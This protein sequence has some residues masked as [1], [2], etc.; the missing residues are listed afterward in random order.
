M[1]NEVFKRDISFINV[2][3]DNYFNPEKW[4]P[5]RIITERIAENTINNFKLADIYDF[6]GEFVRN[7]DIEHPKLEKKEVIISN[8]YNF[9]TTEYNTD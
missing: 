1:E 9:K 5:E 7:L 3:P 6:T 4:A 8:Q 2:S